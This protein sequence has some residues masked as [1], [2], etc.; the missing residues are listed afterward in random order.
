MKKNR[1]ALSDAA[2]SSLDILAHPENAANAVLEIR[3]TRSGKQEKKDF[4]DIEYATVLSDEELEAE[5]F[6]GCEMAKRE[7]SRHEQDLRQVSP[8]GQSVCLLHLLS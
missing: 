6:K 5:G 3:L 8:S 1:S 7:R 2:F 4:Y